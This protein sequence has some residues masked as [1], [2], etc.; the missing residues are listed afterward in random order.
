M[1]SRATTLQVSRVNCPQAL[2]FR[3]QHQRERLAQR[4]L[5][6]IRAAFTV[7]PDG[8][9]TELV[10]R[11]QCAGEVLY[12]HDRYQLQRAGGGLG[13]HTGR[14][15]TVAR[16]GDDRLHGEGRSRAQDGADIVRIGDLVEH[17]HDAV[18]L[19][20]LDV[21]RGQGIGLGEQALVH[22]V[23]R[24]QPVDLLGPDDLGRDRDC[25][26]LVRQTPCGVLGQRQLADLPLGV[27]ERHGDG[28]PAI[29]DDRPV[30]VRITLAPGRPA[31]RFS[32]FFEG[33]TAAAVTLRA[34]F[35]IVHR[36]ACVM[37][38]G[39]WQFGCLRWPF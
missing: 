36:S 30:G 12:R 7:Q 27:G 32:G 2:A 14:F 31:G 19:Q 22:R 4:D 6:E 5:G 13:Q 23:G 28:V 10:Q 26:V 15:R 16:G 17:Q 35:S 9:E 8:L 38:P 24:Q 33:L 39:I 34:E 3:A 37:G 21:G 11:G 1:S 29:E 18:L 20:I 25:D